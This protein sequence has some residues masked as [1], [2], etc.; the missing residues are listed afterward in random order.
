MA[1]AKPR[2]GLGGGVYHFLGAQGFLAAHGFLAAQGLAA[3]GFTALAA[4]GFLAAQGLAERV[5]RL[6]AE[7]GLQGAAMAQP[8]KAAASRP[9]DIR[10][11]AG[12]TVLECFIRD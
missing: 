4:Q 10:K 3:H 2:C 11:A 7:Q 5:V 6:R 9:A 8:L 12:F 1:R